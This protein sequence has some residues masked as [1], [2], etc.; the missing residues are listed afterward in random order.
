MYFSSRSFEC[1]SKLHPD[2]W[3]DHIENIMHGLRP[4]HESRIHTSFTKPQTGAI[5]FDINLPTDNEDFV[6]HYYR[7]AISQYFKGIDGIL[8]RKGFINETLV[9]VPNNAAS[10]NAHL[11][12]NTFSLRVSIGTF[13]DNPELI[14]SYLGHSY[15]LRKKLSEVQRSCSVDSLGYIACGNRLIKYKDLYSSRRPEEYEQMPMLTNALR[16]ELCMEWPMRPKTNRYKTYKEQVDQFVSTYLGTESFR[17]IVPLL[18]NQMLTLSANSVWVLQKDYSTMLFGPDNSGNPHENTDA[19]AGMKACGPYERAQ[20]KV[21]I[22]FI[23]P[24]SEREVVEKWRKDIFGNASGFR[25]FPGYVRIECTA[26]PTH[27]VF[28]S[29]A[30]DQATDIAS[31]IY[32]QE[33][34]DDTEYYAIYFTPHSRA[35]RFQRQQQIYHEVRDILFKRNIQ[36]QCITIGTAKLAEKSIT[37][38]L[39]NIAIASLGK[40]GGT[41]W[42]V[43]P[44]HERELVIGINAFTNQH[45]VKY[46]AAAVCFDST[47]KFRRQS[48][49][50]DDKPTTLAGKIAAEIES[51]RKLYDN[52]KRLIIH[53]YKKMS[54]RELDP[55][56]DMLE[57]LS[58][59][60]DVYVVTISKSESA[61]LLAF[62]ITPNSASLLPCSGT[63][64]R[65]SSQT[66]LL[67]NNTRQN[68]SESPSLAAG[69]PYGLKLHVMCTNKEKMEKGIKALDI[70]AQVYQFSRLYWSTGK[71]QPFP[72]TQLYTERLARHVARTGRTDLPEAGK[73]RP[74]YV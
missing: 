55:I 41:P 26:P 43:K 16:K 74:F 37:Y 54:K 42:A 58:L 56:T 60:I 63:I 22:F 59:D 68:P 36:M 71:Q 6:K 53:Y 15:M 5:P 69:N 10:T 3:P 57:G 32:M 33:R 28:Y 52:P 64:V 12:Y 65:V 2:T 19:F 39:N 70:I 24:Q 66:F 14:V 31:A 30:D 23:A 4:T 72:I 50:A 44:I 17:K 49:F 11:T 27:D 29:N 21:H 35:A 45:G 46:I 62:D 34:R 20:Q 40:L 38:A 47:G 1:S 8:S 9:F 7:N 61:D 18:S 13:T 48:A 25:G 51:Y 73:T 67:F